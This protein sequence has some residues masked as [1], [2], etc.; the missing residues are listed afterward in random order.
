MKKHLT[1]T[2]L[3]LCLAVGWAAAQKT[4]SGTVT[5]RGGEPL[6]GVN[7]LQT[8][9]SIGTVTDV[10]GRYSIRVNAEDA[11]LEFSYTGYESQ[12]VS[13]AGRTTVDVVLSEGVSLNEVVV[14]ALGIS[15]EKKALSYSAQTIG[16]EELT[17]VKD[18]NVVNSLAGKS[19]GVFINRSAS[20]VGGSTRVVL[21]G[22]KSTRDNQPL[23]VIDGV[24][25][26]NYSPAQP[27]D[28][29]GQSSGSGSGGRDG[30]DAISNLNP[31]DIES[32]SVLKGASAS[33]LYGSQ[34]ANGVILITTKKGKAGVTKVEFSSNFTVE[35]PIERPELQ[36][37]YGQTAPG[38][39]DSWGGKVSA[40]D[41]VEDFF[42]TGRTWINSVALSGGNEV[43]Q[44]YF[45]YAN[46]NSQSMMP[47][48]D[49]NR[50]NLT[51]RE[52]AAFF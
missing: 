16:G 24:P 15:R 8:G 6:I 33:A 22:N 46:T 18:A 39:L 1:F 23:Y 51:F 42:E 50:H 25:M 47:T 31:D 27:G 45:S 17:R 32:I 49:F 13:T 5:S 44:T 21:R 3:L 40:P 12:Q 35:Q 41:H 20:G 37:E 14:T 28:V 10:D 48:S 43:A 7:I 19:A 2:L 52:T 34:A 4:V 26:F 9:T 38:A 36:F 30:G 11:V 29:W